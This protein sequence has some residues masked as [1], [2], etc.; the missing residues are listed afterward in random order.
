VGSED[1]TDEGRERKEED[2]GRFS[3]ESIVELE[4]W[5]SIRVMDLLKWRATQE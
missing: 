2:P 4:E 3:K 5:V 1:V